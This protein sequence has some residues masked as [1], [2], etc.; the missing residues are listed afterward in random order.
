MA[1]KEKEEKENKKSWFSTAL[2]TAGGIGLNALTGGLGSAISGVVGDLFGGIFGKSDAE[3]T[4]EMQMQI[5]RETNEMN[6]KIWQEQRQAEVDMWNMNNE[7]NTPEAQRQ[8]LEDAGF[9]PY[10]ML[11]QGGNIGMSSSAPST[12]QAP[13]MQQAQIPLQESRF[14]QGLRALQQST[15]SSLALS[16][17]GLAKSQ[18]GL[19]DAQAGRIQTLLP[20][21]TKELQAQL[22][23]LKEL[24]ISERE[25]QWLMHQQGRILSN[26]IEY[27]N[28]TFMDRVRQQTELTNQMRSQSILLKLNANE[29]SIVSKYLYP[30]FGI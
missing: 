21:E 23:Y 18:A 26:Q 14:M 10:A 12:G 3:K 15:A 30:Q 7:Y 9:S 2:Q 22:D 17:A 20:L 5:A 19:A 27:E 25:K 8:R 11:G 29:R 13:T 28:M 1:E 6:Y 4:A 16:Q 24:P